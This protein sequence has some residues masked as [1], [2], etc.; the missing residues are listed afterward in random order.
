MGISV[1]NGK[2]LELL[3]KKQGFWKLYCFQVW[4]VRL[5]FFKF[6]FRTIF[7]SSEGASNKFAVEQN[8]IKKIFET[9]KK[10]SGKS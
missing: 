6:N 10:I 3:K 7:V 1:E 8:F 5:E 2:F 4:I 9:V